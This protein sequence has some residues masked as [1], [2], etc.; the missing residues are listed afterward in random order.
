MPNNQVF[1]QA[2]GGIKNS[3]AIPDGNRMYELMFW[4]GIEKKFAL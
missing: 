1:G 4:K 2:E 3:K